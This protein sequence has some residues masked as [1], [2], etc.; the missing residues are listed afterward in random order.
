MTLP[1]GVL[2]ARLAS[3][4][5]AEGGRL[6]HEVQRLRFAIEAAEALGNPRRG[7]APIA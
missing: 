3:E 6:R 1:Y 4:P 2:K 7:A 5:R